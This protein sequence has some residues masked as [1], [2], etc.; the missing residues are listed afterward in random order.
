[1]RGRQASPR[2][3]R[4]ARG[5][6]LLASLMCAAA[7]GVEHESG[8]KVLVADALAKL[9]GHSEQH[10]SWT[11]YQTLDASLE[12]ARKV[13]ADNRD[14]ALDA[15]VPL[16]KS[17]TRDAFL[18][19]DLAAFVAATA[20][21]ESRL[22][23]AAAVLERA[24]VRTHPAA[25][26]R[27]LVWMGSRS[28]A[29]CLPAMFRVLDLS[30]ARAV[31]P[32]TGLR[33]DNQ[34]AVFLFVFGQYGD[35]ALPGLLERLGSRDCAVRTYAARALR[36]VRPPDIPPSLR[37]MAI[38]RETCNSARTEAWHVLGE[39]D[40]PEMPVLARRRLDA[41]PAPDTSERMDIAGGLLASWVPTAVEVLESMRDDPN[42]R[43]QPIVRA[44]LSPD[45]EMDTL[46]ERIGGRP[47]V[48]VRPEDRERRLRA[49]EEG[50]RTG[51]YKM[52]E[53]SPVFVPSMTLADIP[54][55]ER[56]RAA[57]LRR[58]TEDAHLHAVRLTMAEREIRLVHAG[59]PVPLP[60]RVAAA[61]P[62]TGGRFSLPPDVEAHFMN[63]YGKD[64][65]VVSKLKETPDG[66]L[67][68]LSV[69]GNLTVENP[70]GATREE[71]ARSATLAFLKREADLLGIRD[72]AEIRETRLKF[73]DSQRI[74]RLRG[75]CYVDY[76][77]VLGGI[78]LVWNTYGF[79]L[80]PN[81]VIESFHA[82]VV[83]VSPGLDAAVRHA[84]ISADEARSVVE[85][86]LD[87]LGLEKS[88][89]MPG[90]PALAAYY[91][92]PFIL[93]EI[94]GRYRSGFDQVAWYYGVDALTG[95][96]ARRTCSD[97]RRGVSMA[98]SGPVP[99]PCDAIPGIPKEPS[100]LPNPYNP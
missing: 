39:L 85:R 18:I 64:A 70:G 12:S 25:T 38:D 72:F 36:W 91:Q 74:E 57:V 41:S 51:L 14:A 2:A 29:S 33:F 34:D 88:A 100:T 92:A 1:M 44:G 80:N 96:I 59:P 21:D 49:L 67:G 66:P 50:A 55:I 84:R 37:A 6:L 26:I 77:R 99:G 48:P 19:V 15:I 89:L 98:P 35:A 17:E 28:C 43:V 60:P 54:L 81:G 78:P 61:P 82:A 3:T 42:P 32:Q 73:D 30:Y 94:R 16:L 83:P 20:S 9:R 7:A 11:E 46:L 68:T 62:P 86:D 10:L 27:A 13:L 76:D 5:A 23:T 52:E 97:G 75:M 53:P 63:R 69:S 45:R 58:L 90:E 65:T 31:I 4:L 71:R 40:D 56:T 8:P 79:I 22:A 47:G 95:T 24:D 93:W 87:A